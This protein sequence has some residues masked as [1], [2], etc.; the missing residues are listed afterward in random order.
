MKKFTISAA[1]YTHISNE[2]FKQYLKDVSKIELFTT[3]EE[4][5]EVAEKASLGDKKALDELIARNLRFVVSVAKQYV[6]SDV[7]IEDL[8]NEGNYGLIV[9]ANKFVPSK[10]NKFISFSIWWIRKYILEYLT[11]SAKTIRI[12]ANRVNDLLN[13]KKKIADLEQ[14]NQTNVNI[15]EVIYDNSSIYDKFEVKNYR[16]LESIEKLKMY[17]FDKEIGTDGN[18]TLNDI[19]SSDLPPT[20]HL[21]IETETSIQV[22]KNLGVL[23]QRDRNILSDLFGLD[24]TEILTL[25][26]VAIKYNLSN[27]RVRQVREISLRKLKKTFKK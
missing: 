7:C 26:E 24:G 19:I 5:F 10:G 17:S 13:L 11:N 1:S 12:P 6:S 27:E 8:V 23:N 22:K 25:T 18:L 15:E 4:E 20:D 2:S 16:L 21:L 9:A 3:A 14:K